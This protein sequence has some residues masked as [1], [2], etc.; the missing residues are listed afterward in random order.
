MFI[1]RISK[2]LLYKRSKMLISIIIPTYNRGQWISKTINSVL[3]QT[4]RKFEIIVIDDG[5]TDNT[6]NILNEFVK[7][8]S[9]IRYFKKINGGCSS[10]R[11]LGLKY[12]KGELIAFLD[13]DD[14]YLPNALEVLQQALAKDRKANFAYSPSIEVNEN[15]TE[16]INFPAAAAKPEY[17]AVEHFKTF[18]ARPGSVLYKREIFKKV[19]GFN[20]NFKYNEDSDFLQRV[21]I[22]F[23]ATYCPSP[24]VKV[25]SHHGNKSKNRTEIYKVALISISDIEKEFPQF[26]NS[27]INIHSARVLELKEKLV[28]LL[29]IE[30]KYDQA[31]EIYNNLKTRKKLIISFSLKIKSSLPLRLE[32]ALFRLIL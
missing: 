3:N 1:Y 32:L 31:S 24:T 18:N 9:N 15:G 19:H 20:E 11:N 22:C 10:A 6:S 25:Y 13:S 17:F 21:A 30:K 12:A 28:E 23:N 14:Q 8:N 26:I 5:S 7:S 4:Y 2:R 16:S 27:I 29:I